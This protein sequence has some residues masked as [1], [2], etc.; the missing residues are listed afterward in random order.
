MRDSRPCLRKSNSKRKVKKSGRG[1]VSINICHGESGPDDAV[2][3]WGP[4]AEQRAAM[5][6]GEPPPFDDAYDR[7]TYDL[8]KELAD[9]L[10]GGLAVESGNWFARTA[11]CI[12]A[13]KDS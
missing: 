11:F 8:N 6:C 10:R 3:I 12:L 4:N 7:A 1:S 5:W 9:N 13:V 2:A